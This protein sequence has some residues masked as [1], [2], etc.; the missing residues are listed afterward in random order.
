MIAPMR[1]GVCAVLAVLLVILVQ[2]A[3]PPTLLLVAILA[4]LALWAL[5]AVPASQ[6]AVLGAGLI[7]PALIAVFLPGIAVAWVAAALLLGGTVYRIADLRL[8]LIRTIA[9]WPTGWIVATIA[10]ALLA[11]AAGALSFTE[12]YDTYCAPVDT[13]D[14][15]VL[16]GRSVTCLVDN[17]HR[18]GALFALGADWAFETRPGIDPVPF[19]W[20]VQILRI[21]MPLVAVGGILLLV[22]RWLGWRLHEVTMPRRGHTVVAG[23]GQAGGILASHWDIR[24]DGPVLFV[25]RNPDPAIARRTRRRGIP[26]IVGDVL[27]DDRVLKRTKAHRAARVICLLPE[28]GANIDMALSVQR[29]CDRGGRRGTGGPAG[30]RSFWDTL[31]R[32]LRRAAVGPDFEA[33]TRPDPVIQVHVDHPQLVGR[34]EYYEKITHMSAIDV[35]F[36]NLYTEAAIGLLL[37][38]PPA[39]FADL[40]GQARVHLAI[41]GFGFMGR[42]VLAEALRHCHYR[43]AS[44]PLISIV[45]HEAARVAGLLRREAPE[46]DQ[47]ADIAVYEHTFFR[48]ALSLDALSEAAPAGTFGQPPERDSRTKAQPFGAPV[49]AHILCFDDEVRALGLGLALREQLLIPPKANAP[50]FV[51]LKR[52]AGLAALLASHAGRKELPDGLYP[53]G[54]LDTVLTPDALKDARIDALAQGIHFAYQEKRRDEG[55]HIPVKPWPELEDTH[56]RTSRRAAVHAFAKLTGFDYDIRPPDRSTPLPAAP[57]TIDAT[58]RERLAELE[59]RRFMASH[60]MAGHVRADRRSD[61]LKRHAQLVDWSDLSE[62]MRDNDRRLTASL[63]GLMAADRRTLEGLAAQQDQKP[64][65]IDTVWAALKPVALSVRPIRRLGVIALPDGDPDVMALREARPLTATDLSAAADRLVRD[66]LTVRGS[67]AG[68]SMSTPRVVPQQGAGDALVVEAGEAVH[69]WTTLTTGAERA[70]AEA[71]A[72]RRGWPLVAETKRDSVVRGVAVSPPPP[73]W[74]PRITALL[75]LPHELWERGSIFAPPDGGETAPREAQTAF[76][77]LIGSQEVRYVELPMLDADGGLALAGWGEAPTGSSTDGERAAA[78]AIE[79]ERIE[80][81]RRQWLLALAHLRRACAPVWLLVRCDAEF[82]L[83]NTWWSRHAPTIRSDLVPAPQALLPVKD[84]TADLLT[85][86]LTV[87]PIGDFSAESMNEIAP[88]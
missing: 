22:L 15:P 81:Q 62:S 79:A 64:S 34:L 55:A 29:L 26:V 14:R 19:G 44:R 52:Q 6:V 28:D 85:D 36:L 51:R 50:I 10:L 84:L 12:R 48:A 39:L 75:P 70:V 65:D 3:D 82:D 7:L 2:P 78:A 86:R 66:R 87:C 9:G 76:T 67:V 60:R 56:R 31:H 25:D 38:N 32:R 35:R 33:R 73:F 23:L 71:V 27:R 63:P 40:Q 37:D 30:R 4:G 5:L 61:A 16:L 53:F 42:Q 46:L 20:E 41:Y 47:V 18:A 17:L 77:E 45:D 57:A 49:T 11:F 24:R 83:V 43:N 1:Y 8:T 13:A 68:G 88:S 58:D 72:A 21:V 69:L 80:A 74:A 59:H 54:M